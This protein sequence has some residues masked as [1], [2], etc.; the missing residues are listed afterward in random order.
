M[1]K[2]FLDKFTATGPGLL[3]SRF[4]GGHS[5]PCSPQLFVLTILHGFRSCTH[6]RLKQVYFFTKNQ[7]ADVQSNGQGKAR[8]AAPKGWTIELTD[9]SLGVHSPNMSNFQVCCRHVRGPSMHAKLPGPSKGHCMRCILGEKVCCGHARSVN[10]NAKL[11]GAFNEPAGCTL[12]KG[13]PGACRWRMKKVVVHV[14]MVHECLPGAWRWACG[15]YMVVHEGRGARR[16]LRC[17][18]VI[19]GL[20][21]APTGTTKVFQERSR[22]L[23]AFPA[24]SCAASFSRARGS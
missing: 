9:F 10:T 17:M 14:G 13:L 6:V 12:Y 5:V 24:L 20:T 18:E 1:Q 4:E 22:P 7:Y 19:G 15:W 11:P 2:P 23:F 3:M 16:S 8:L 21:G